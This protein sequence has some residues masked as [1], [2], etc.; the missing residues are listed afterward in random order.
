MEKQP[1]QIIEELLCINTD[2]VYDWVILQ[3]NVNTN[4]LA[5]DLGG[6]PIDPCGPTVSNLTTECYLTDAAGNRLGP[7]SVID[8]VETRDRE[9]R[10]F[11]IDGTE[12]ILQNVAFQKTIFL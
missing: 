6:L 12:V 10:A 5:A 1:K 7:N 11:I 8:V 2:K 4:V 9:D 3:S